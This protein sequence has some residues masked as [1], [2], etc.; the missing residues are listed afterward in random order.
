M[1][2]DEIPVPQRIKGRVLKV[3]QEFNTTPSAMSQLNVD[4]G[5][6]FGQAV[7]DFCD[8]HAVNRSDIDLI[9]SH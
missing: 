3:L 2:Y 1:Q 4:L 6:M 9:G 7:I 5:T 8:K